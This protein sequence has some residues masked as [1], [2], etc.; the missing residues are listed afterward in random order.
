MREEEGDGKKASRNLSNCRSTI[1]L[2]S[3]MPYA[4]E[5][6]HED[7]NSSA[8]KGGPAHSAAAW[9]REEENLKGAA[10]R[11]KAGGAASLAAG[12]ARQRR[13]EKNAI[14]QN[15]IMASWKT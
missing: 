6:Q 9:R 1:Y 5:R 11:R 2:L 3:A 4:G 12:R 14:S 7:S 8:R 15:D 13:G 10:W